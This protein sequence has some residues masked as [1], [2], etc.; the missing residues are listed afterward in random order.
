MRW[1]AV[2]LASL[3][4]NAGLAFLW[5]GGGRGANPRP[6]PAALNPV[7]NDNP[8]PNIV[9]RRQFFS[10]HEVE[11]PDY[12]TYIANLR[13]ISCPEQTIR[14]II[15]A[16]VNSLYAKRRARELITPEQQWWRL[17]PDTNVLRVAAEKSRQ[18]D[19]ERRA[20]LARLLGANW[21]S[22]D[23]AGLPRPSRPGVNLDGPVLGEMSGDTKQA[24]QE[25]STRSQDRIQAYLES[26]QAQG[27]EPDPAELARLRRQTREELARVLSPGQL[28]EFLLRYSQNAGALRTTFGSLQF[29]NPSADEFRAVFRATDSLDQRIEALAGATDPNS[30]QARQ[31]LEAQRETAIKLALGPQRYEQYQ[32]LQDPLYRDAVATAQ[33]AGMPE[34]A[35]TLYEVNLAA[36]QQQEAIRTNTWLTPEQKA[37]ELKQLEVDQMRANAVATGKAL[38]PEP[39]PP[40]PQQ[41]KR[42]Y[43]VIYGDTV[44]VLSA[45]FGIPISAIRDANPN[46][47]LNKVKPGDTIMLPRS[48]LTPAQE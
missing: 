29:F 33:E 47:D 22:G 2:A 44:A 28:E 5:W 1:R 18:L 37:I 14:D 15:I 13:D 25:L 32:N 41:P 48:F 39:T 38:P 24:V 6:Q 45:Q 42:P 3:S 30:I 7:T 8:R 21:E 27:Q 20:L 35:R 26:R 9:V 11:S 19:G 46:V 4:L 36:V 10:W 17:E 16:D 40:P 34:T 23:L 31:A 12:P 43:T